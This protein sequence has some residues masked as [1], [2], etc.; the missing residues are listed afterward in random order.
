MYSKAPKPTLRR[1]FNYG[2]FLPAGS[3]GGSVDDGFVLTGSWISPLGLNVRMPPRSSISR[4]PS[5]AYR[6]ITSLPPETA[7]QTY[8]RYIMLEAAQRNHLPVRPLSTAAS[9]R[10]RHSSC[11]IAQ[12]RKTE[13]GGGGNIIPEAKEE[14]RPFITGEMKEGSEIHITISA[15]VNLHKLSGACKCISMS[16]IISKAEVTLILEIN[17]FKRRRIIN[18]HH[19]VYLQFHSPNNYTLLINTIFL[20]FQNEFP[21]EN[22]SGRRQTARKYKAA[23]GKALQQSCSS[24]RPDTAENYFSEN[25]F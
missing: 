7:V 15:T 19:E 11:L 16:D 1:L 12:R 14:V 13:A 4:T 8:I 6:E 18:R 2:Q 20:Q 9:V 3:A 22:R 5:I 10:L 24:R 21:D 25:V 23:L 17:I